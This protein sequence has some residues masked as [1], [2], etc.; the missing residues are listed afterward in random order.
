MSTTPAYDDLARRQ[1]RQH[2]LGHLQAIAQ[3]D[4]SA[5]MPAQGAEARGLALAEM[6]G[7]LH[8]LA[9]DAAL[10]GLLDTAAAEPL[11]DIQKA[12]L[13]E[14]R[15]AWRSANALPQ[16]LVEAKS[17]ANSRCE[18]A[19]RSQRAANDWAGFAPNLREVLK[20]A[21]EEAERLSQQAGLSR[22][23]ALLDLYEPGMRSAEV[24]RVFG[25]LRGWLPGLIRDVTARQASET[26]VRPAGPFPV[27]AQR[28]LGRDAMRLMGFDFG[29]GRLDESAHPFCGGVPED[30]RMTT[31][32]RE[33]DFLPA[34]MGVIH[35]TGHGRYEQNLPRE[36][37]GQPIAR[38]RSMG[39]HESQSLSF[40]MQLGSH[41]A[42][43]GLLAPLL[44]KHFGAQPAFE[45]A[46]LH[47][48]L[49]RVQPGLIRVDADEVTYPAHVILRFEIERA[50]IEGEAQVD[51]IPAL[52]DAKMA[53]LLGLDTRGNFQDG[54]MQDVHWPAGL[55]GYFP[56]YTL[57]AMYAAQWFATMRSQHPALDEQIARGELST[58]FDWLKTQ[59]WQQ[60]SRYETPELVLRASGEALNPGHFE[61]HLRQRYLG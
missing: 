3:W 1:L 17:L 48:L 45:T 53:E 46:N 52:W 38:A 57:G 4:Q 30:V 10:A 47:R 22:Y 34:L 26:V 16:A 42:F 37:L 13:R 24:A 6:D 54:P 49:T 40:E 56:C 21:R 31:R 20:L 59:V 51:D 55:F 28:A 33:D 14:I 61:A 27:A 12:N 15:R 7:L 58:V 23:D 39:I 60:A 19:W 2:R 11:D 43:A 50:L 18:H 41:P 44:V 5:F 36:L 29:A 8:E 9:T 25:E 32:Y 35:E